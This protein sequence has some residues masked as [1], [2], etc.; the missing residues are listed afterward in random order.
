MGASAP[1]VLLVFPPAMVDFLYPELGMPQLTGFLRHAGLRTEQRDLNVELVN[2]R[3]STREHMSMIL[4]SPG[5]RRMLEGPR[6]G[7]RRDP[8][9]RL[10]E[11]YRRDPPARRALFLRLCHVLD[12]QPRSTRI[13]DVLGWAEAAHDL[14]D[15]FFEDSLS[16]LLAAGPPAVAGLSVCSSTQI[17]PA[18]KAALWL[19][20]AG[21]GHVVIGGPWARAARQMLGTWKYL[22]RHV[23]SFAVSDGER[24]LL[25]LAR[26]VK[27]EKDP[28]SVPGLVTLNSGK[29]VSGPDPERIPLEQMP[30]ADFGGLDMDRYENRWLPVRSR[31]TCPWGQCVFCHHVSSGDE[32]G[33]R[34]LPARAVV[35]TMQSLHDHHGVRVFE[36]A[37]LSTPAKELEAIADEILARK[38]DV[39]WISL[40][41]IE[42]EFTREVIGK[43]AGSGCVELQFG[44]ESVVEDDLARINKGITRRDVDDLLEA[45]ESSGIRVNM[46]VIN[47]P[48]QKRE[49]FVE[50]LEFCC[51]NH[52][53]V[54]NFPVQRFTLS[55]GSGTFSNPETLGITIDKAARDDLDVFEVPYSAADELPMQEFMRLGTHY[56]VRFR[57][58][59][60]GS[61]PTFWDVQGIVS[62]LGGSKPGI[63]SGKARGERPLDVLLARASLPGARIRGDEP[64]PVAPPLG[65][66]YLSSAIKERSRIPHRVRVADLGMDCTTTEEIL[67]LVAGHDAD[68]VGISA[69]NVDEPV[70]H[71]LSRYSKIID[72]AC[73][74][75]VGGAITTAMGERLSEDPFIDILCL[76]EG[77]ETLPELLDVLAAGG[78]VTR[79]AGLIVK[80][81]YQ[82]QHRTRARPFIRDVDAIGFPDWDQIV[83]K[84]YGNLCNCNEFP[85]QARIYSPVFT[86]RGCPWKCI[87]CH[88]HFG[89]RPR[90]RSADN[91]LDEI[92]TLVS[93]H[94]VGE[95]HVHD[96]IF[97]IDPERLEQICDGI[98]ERGIEVHIAFPNGVRADRLTRTHIEKLGAAGCYHM[99]MAF[100][101]V[102][103]RLQKMIRKNL[104]VKKVLENARIA[105]ELGIVTAC[106][107]ML[108]FP[109]ETRDEIMDTINTVAESHFDY[110]RLFVACPHPGTRL[111]DVALQHGF[112]PSTLT[113]DRFEYDWDRTGVNCTGLPDEEFKELTNLCQE[114]FLT[115]PARLERLRRIHERF[116]IPLK[117]KHLSHGIMVDL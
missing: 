102:T 85:M 100:E 68:V 69:N 15:G 99:C 104:K 77:E 83:L 49:D 17:G 63:W 16:D 73:T 66:L 67:G 60:K 26:A 76:H 12:L 27:Q 117:G 2:H 25:E 88:N 21:C 97:N 72:P 94:G 56:S 36:M 109:T 58:L 51:E 32:D 38:L 57:S 29:V 90:C 55:R 91:V 11:T 110:M 93:E 34:A 20:N 53:R 116:K 82:K 47:F 108:G 81:E 101:T 41:R 8:A 115:H 48:G 105:S 6:K 106:F 98:V 52:E 79:V 40:V 75:I 18:L 4:A 9:S 74:V 35:D 37:N 86:S 111:H 80:D 43:L 3:F 107:V 87:F 5:W 64:P 78:D 114:R 13:E 23:D 19:K 59:G 31:R 103:P 61:S 71:L 50:T 39:E 1:E 54:H 92:E 112:D 30:P 10:L 24:T 46:F 14:Y 84:D 44:L 28:S 89:R 45:S 113:P 96:D 95:I 33:E 70:L 62:R 42:R 22:F 7:R 65:V